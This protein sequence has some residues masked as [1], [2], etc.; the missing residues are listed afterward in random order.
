MDAG[1][2]PRPARRRQPAASEEVWDLQAPQIPQ[3]VGGGTDEAVDSVLRSGISLPVAA[4]TKWRPLSERAVTSL[5]DVLDGSRLARVMATM[6]V[7]LPRAPAHRPVTL[8]G[9]AHLIDALAEALTSPDLVAAPAELAGVD[10]YAV[11]QPRDLHLVTARPLSS[12]LDT[13]ALTAIRGAGT[14]HGAHLLADPARD[15]AD[16]AQRWT[17]V[18]QWIEQIALDGGMTGAERLLQHLPAPSPGPGR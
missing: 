10:A 1:D 12:V 5:A 8:P 17:Q 14:S 7:G 3:Q 18:L 16:P 2:H 15:L 13:A 6:A 9:T 11:P 4:A